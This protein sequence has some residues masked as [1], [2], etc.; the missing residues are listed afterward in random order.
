MLKPANIDLEL[1]VYD[2]RLWDDGLVVFRNKA[3][4]HPECDGKPVEDPNQQ[5]TCGIFWNLYLSLLNS[6]GNQETEKED[7]M[8]RT[9]GT[10]D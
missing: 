6:R 8:R 10:S 9:V 1:E 7:V 2:L 3:C 5:A 4:F